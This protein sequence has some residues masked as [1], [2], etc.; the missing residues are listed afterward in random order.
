MKFK[1]IVL[2]VLS[3]SISA[4]AKEY[5]EQGLSF[6]ALGDSTTYGA[7]SSDGRSWSDIL[8]EMMSFDY[9][10]KCAQNG[11][12]CLYHPGYN[13][14][15]NQIDRVPKSTRGF[16]TIMIGTNDFF[17]DSPLGSANEALLTPESELNDTRTFANAFR[18]CLLKIRKKAPESR[19]IVILPLPTN[20]AGNVNGHYDESNL[21][22]IR[23]I[24]RDICKSMGIPVVE[25]QLVFGFSRDR[26]NWYHYFTDFCHPND[27]G[28][29]RIADCMYEFMQQY[30]K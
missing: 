16:I 20:D 18:Y 6:F 25:S 4:C 5:D 17:Y 28:Y 23:D 12:F 29:R 8:S 9:Y 3:L 21:S 10:R 13:R 19:I 14:L 1:K 15:S 22:I 24:Q 26:G 27:A 7:G 30:I 2:V 11:S